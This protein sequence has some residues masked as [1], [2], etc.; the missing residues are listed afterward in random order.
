MATSIG[1]LVS[2]G[3]KRRVASL[4]AVLSGLADTVPEV[5]FLVHY[6]NL[7]AGFFGITGVAHAA[8]AGTVMKFK[9]T[10]TAS[11]LVAFLAAAQAYPVLLPFVPL[12]QKLAF[13]FGVFGLVKN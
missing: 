10:S 12:V 11:F 9:A 6:V 7:V 1:L 13:M 3:L 8:K 2:K 4:L 5:G